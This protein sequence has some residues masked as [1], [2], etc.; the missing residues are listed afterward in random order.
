MDYDVHSELL[1]KRSSEAVTAIRRYQPDDEKLHGLLAFHARDIARKIAAHLRRHRHEWPA[2]YELVVKEAW[3]PPTGRS[4]T[5]LRD[6]PIAS[7]REP[8]TNKA[9]IRQMHFGGFKRCLFS[10][11][12]FE[13]HGERRLSVLLEDAPERSLRW[14]RPGKQDVRIYWS[15]E[16]Q[17]VPDFIVET[18]THRLIVEICYRDSFRADR[19]IS[20]SGVSQGV[21]APFGGRRTRATPL[22]AATFES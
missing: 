3:S 20:D 10:E 7:Y 16:R 19:R 6:E 1:Y 18:A 4:R 11:V 15:S 13:S 8:V 12:Q 21:N 17:Y 14:F 9:R 22:C 5:G 2:G